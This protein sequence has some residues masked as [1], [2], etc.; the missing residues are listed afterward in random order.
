MTDSLSH[1]T[2]EVAGELSH[3]LK[4]G[5][6]LAPFLV[7]IERYIFSDWVFLAFLTVLVV[8]DTLLGFGYAAWKKRISTGKLSGIIAKCVVYGSVLIVGHV[9]EN[10]QISGNVIPGGIYFKMTCYGGVIL[11]EAISIIKNLGK[12][13]KNLVPQFILKRLEG[14]NDTGDFQE[15]T[16]RNTPKPTQDEYL[17]S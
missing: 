11:L 10:V 5:F 13:N 6:T 16:K 4:Y 17:D 1:R 9:I 2:I 3:K 8:L 7:L 12:I 14:F 15:L